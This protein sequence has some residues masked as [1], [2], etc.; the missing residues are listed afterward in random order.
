MHSAAAVFPM[1]TKIKRLCK[2]T[3]FR[4]TMN[5]PGQSKLFHSP[6]LRCSPFAKLSFTML[7]CKFEF[8]ALPIGTTQKSEPRNVSSGYDVA[9]LV[10]I[11]SSALHLFLLHLAPESKRKFCLHKVPGHTTKPLCFLDVNR[12]WDNKLEWPFI[13]WTQQSN[14]CY[15]HS[16]VHPHLCFLK[17]NMRTLF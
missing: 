1:E 7:T 14:E 3:R 2:C 5:H 4:C 17:S 12:L 13:C 10:A 6:A 15:L 11:S 16:T 9:S 8:L